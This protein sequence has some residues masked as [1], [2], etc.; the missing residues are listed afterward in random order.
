MNKVFYNITPIL[1]VFYPTTQS[2]VVSL[3]EAQ[4]TCLKTVALSVGD[5]ATRSGGDANRPSSATLTSSR[6]HATF[7]LSLFVLVALCL[8]F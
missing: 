4:L 6:A 8:I 1:T 5:N 2:A 3:P 7:G